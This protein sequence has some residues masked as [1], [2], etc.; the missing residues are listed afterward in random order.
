M[1]SLTML[2]AGLA[3]AGCAAAGPVAPES[4]TVGE[5]RQ[6][7]A[8]FE[9]LDEQRTIDEPSAMVVRYGRERGIC[10]PGE[11]HLVR[12]H[13]RMF[14]SVTASEAQLACDVAPWIER[15][16]ARIALAEPLQAL[17]RES[18]EQGLCALGQPVQW[19]A[20][21]AACQRIARGAPAS[22]E[23]T[24]LGL[25]GVA[26]G[27]CDDWGHGDGAVEPWYGPSEYAAMLAGQECFTPAVPGGRTVCGPPRLPPDDQ[28]LATCQRV[29]R[30]HAQGRTVD[31]G[32]ERLARQGRQAGICG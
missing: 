13:Q 22:F 29:A 5:I 2:A 26:S 32:S 14:M 4:L 9:G 1:Q 30:A 18:A 6:V 17:A 15:D 3:L 21:E 12:V 23:D 19:S 11:R 25:A 10:P 28:V 8:A 7:C 20:A 24:M 16:R 31:E 27:R